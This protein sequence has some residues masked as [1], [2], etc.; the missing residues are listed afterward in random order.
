MQGSDKQPQ[1]ERALPRHAG[2]PAGIVFIMTGLDKFEDHWWWDNV[3]HFCGG[4]SVGTVLHEAT[5]DDTG[6]LAGFL[7]VTTLWEAFEYSVGERPWDGS[8]C[9][10]HAMEDTVLDTVMGFLGAYVAVKAGLR[11]VEV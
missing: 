9:W 5:D 11:E 3:A 4:L 6:A 7:L 8:M 2:I 10:D 1:A